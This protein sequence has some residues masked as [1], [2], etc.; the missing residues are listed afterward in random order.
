[1]DSSKDVLADGVH[2]NVREKEADGR[3]RSETRVLT[4][5]ESVTEIRDGWRGDMTMKRLEVGYRANDTGKRSG[6]WKVI[7]DVYV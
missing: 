5:P 1:M 3:D 6:D 7:S 2:H 4:V